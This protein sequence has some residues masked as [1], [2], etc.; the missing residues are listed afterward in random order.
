MKS[1][2]LRNAIRT[3]ARAVAW[4]DRGARS[5][6]RVAAL[7]FRSHLADLDG[8]VKEGNR[9]FTAAMNV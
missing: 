5:A 7:I 6:M 3:L 8:N 9:L 2:L 1:I 4:R